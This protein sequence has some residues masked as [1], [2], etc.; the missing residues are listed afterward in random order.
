M[1]FTFSTS[2]NLKWWKDTEDR[3]NSFLYCDLFDT[4]M[5]CELQIA[6][7]K[8]PESHSGKHTRLVIALFARFTSPSSVL[9]H[10]L[11]RSRSWLCSS[12]VGG[13]NSIAF[14]RRPMYHQKVCQKVHPKC[15]Y[16]RCLQNM[17]FTQ[18]SFS[19]WLPAYLSANLLEVLWAAQK[20]NWITTLDMSILSPSRNK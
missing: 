17:T 20:C 14:L 8:A 1:H 12:R 6:V 19:H 2:L 5:N 10:F 3:L 16:C 15:Q 13:G 18:V 11:L 9:S 7:V 4:F